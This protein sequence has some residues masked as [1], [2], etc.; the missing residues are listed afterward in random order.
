M[1]VHY[2]FNAVSF[3][4]IQDRNYLKDKYSLGYLIEKNTSEFSSANNVPVQIVLI[5]VPFDEKT[6]NKGS[7]QAPDQIRQFLYP[8]S[9]FNAK[10]RIIDLGNIK[11]GKSGSDIYFAVRDVVD[12]FNDI[13]AVSIVI[14]G[15]QDISVG[16]ARA[17]SHET[18]FQI[19]AVDPAI[20]MIS[21]REPFSSKNY[22][23]KVLKENPQVFN[24]SFIGFQ[25]YF[26]SQKIF[27][28]VRENDFDTLRLGQVREKIAEL[29]PVLRNSHFVSFDFSSI[30]AQDAPGCHGGSPNGLYSEEA[31]Q[32]ARYAGISSNLK[33]F[34]L[35]E[36]NPPKDELNL[37]SKLAAQVIWYFIEGFLNRRNENPLKDAA[38][39]TEYNVKLNDS[40]NP[41]VFYRHNFTNRWW[42]QL[43]GPRK[44]KLT[45]ACSEADYKLASANEIPGRWLKYIRKID[46]LSK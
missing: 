31:C 17:F 10:L 21:G 7:S 14:G 41:L 19:A 36:V 8:L 46:R 42:M 20:D 2:Y 23:S 27:R 18:Y 16:V 43:E 30:R 32:V 12:Y 4:G 29:E 45:I 24:I 11:K 39:F 35:F 33:V 34:G 3:S 26:V 28:I 22:I 13:G 1:D 37:S 5:G 9:A 25:S 15:G 44:K 40:E 6:P 38:D